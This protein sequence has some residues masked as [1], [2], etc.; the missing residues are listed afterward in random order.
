MEA[1]EDRRCENNP[2]FNS[3]DL[4][5]PSLQKS[6][7]QHLFDHRDHKYHRKACQPKHPAVGEGFLQV[8]HGDLVG[9]RGQTNP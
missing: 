9:M 2:L 3:E 6:P 1:G 4:P 8:L 7:E 5:Q